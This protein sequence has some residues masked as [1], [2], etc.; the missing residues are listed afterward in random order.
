MSNRVHMLMT[1]YLVVLLTG[2]L[3]NQLVFAY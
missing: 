1:M 3:I 2:T